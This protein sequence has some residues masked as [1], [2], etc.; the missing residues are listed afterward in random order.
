MGN[1]L[2]R[3]FVGPR[4]SDR[5]NNINFIRFIAASAV[6]YGHMAHLMGV[7]VPLLCGEEI[8]SLAV[9]VFFVLSGYLITQSYFRDGHPFR[10]LVR[11][12][13]RI[14][15]GLIFVVCVTTLLFG[16]L[17]TVLSPYEYFTNPH[18][19]DYL[20]NC[21]L[22]PRYSLPGVF[23]DV[24]YPNAMNGSLW[25]LPVEFA[26]YLIAPLCLIPLRKLKIEIPG[27]VVLSVG[28]SL[29]SL[30]NM[31]GVIDL[32]RVVW[33]T[34]IA[35]GMVLVP[36]FFFGALAIYPAINRHLNLQ[37]S[38]VLLL[39][40]AAVQADAYWKYEIFVLALLPY[41]ALAW[42]LAKPAFF[43]RVFSENDFSYGIYL[44]AFPV[45]QTLIQVFGP[46]M[47]GLMA[48][49][50]FAF[51]CT[52]PF[53]IVSWFLVERPCS[54]VGKRLTSWSRAH[55]DRRNAESGE[56]KA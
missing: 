28:S 37:L 13:F 3:I 1:R 5:H 11:R 30:C 39:I 4:E 10:Y 15:P 45:Q 16:P 41:C 46:H 42:A 8:S 2:L 55:E 34:N 27:L 36:Y 25:T 14:F 32:S 48:Y 19:W 51:F 35:D 49:S 18:T 31:A 12:V 6:I 43:G 29:L 40:L 33:G 23:T 44:W 26:M 17:L 20:F 53:A 24:P 50:V 21:L 7:N 56:G 38:F 47:M 9:K 54:R 22:R 52:L